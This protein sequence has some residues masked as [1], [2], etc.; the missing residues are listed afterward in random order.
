[1]GEGV[2]AGS[3]VELEAVNCPDGNRDPPTGRRREV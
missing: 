2:G 3:R 1:M